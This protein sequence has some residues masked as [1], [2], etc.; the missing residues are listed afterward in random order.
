MAHEKMKPIEIYKKIQKTFPEDI[1]RVVEEVIDPYIIVKREAIVKVCKF[2]KE[3]PDLNFDFL[4]CI[5]GVDDGKNFWVVYHLHSIAKNHSCVVK[6]RLPREDPWTYSVMDVWRGA[7]WLERETY[8]MFGIR[9]EGH[10]D[11]RRI[12]LPEDWKGH[13]L[14]KDYEFPDEYRGIWMK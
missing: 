11:L 7:N 14:K 12:L 1:E 3:E 8:D 13:P 9:F 6:V 5:S 10:K 2:L 4:L